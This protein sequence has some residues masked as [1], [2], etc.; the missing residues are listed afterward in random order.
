MDLRK[1]VCDS[2]VCGV[3]LQWALGIVDRLC[4]QIKEIE[5]GAGV[6]VLVF[7]AF[8]MGGRA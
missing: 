3:D 2:A 7:A 1:L 6:P 4:H 8:K 5:R